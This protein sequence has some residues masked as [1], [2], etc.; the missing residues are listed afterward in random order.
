M[1]T[2]QAKFLL[3]TYLQQL[4]FE[5]DATRRVIAAV[6]AGKGDYRPDPK[7]MNAAELA[8]HIASAEMWFMDGVANGEFGKGGAKMPE[9]LKSGAD[10]AAWYEKEFAAR[11]ARLESLSGDQLTRNINFFGVF[12]DAAVGF[13]GLAIRH[14]V[15]HRGQLSAYLRPMGAKVPRIYGGSADEPMEMPAETASA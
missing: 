11:V 15:H 12:Q 5:S 7:C 14:S 10:I 3:D 4:K 9:T 6:P 13:L 1:Q 8:W 2:D